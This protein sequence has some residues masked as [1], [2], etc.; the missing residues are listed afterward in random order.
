LCP[1]AFFSLP[2]STAAKGQ[3]KPTVPAVR[4][5]EGHFDGSFGP[6]RSAKRGTNPVERRGGGVTSGAV[7]AVGSIYR[8][9]CGT[10]AMNKGWRVG[11]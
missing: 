6:F 8:L 1:N 11:F 9:Q 2:T 5:A 4:Q 3:K 7:G 10:L